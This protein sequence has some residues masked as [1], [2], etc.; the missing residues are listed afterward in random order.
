MTDAAPED[1]MEHSFVT[2]P[3][4]A[5]RE[6]AVRRFVVLFSMSRE[7][8]DE[9]GLGMGLGDTRDAVLNVGRGPMTYRLLSATEHER[10]VVKTQWVALS[11]YDQLMNE[12]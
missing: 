3:E 6:A 11:E 8:F 2:S 12:A 9:M 10:G 5:K 4:Q 7:A 1:V